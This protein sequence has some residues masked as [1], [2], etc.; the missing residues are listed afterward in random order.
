MAE[1]VSSP[2]TRVV[3]LDLSIMHKE[4]NRHLSRFYWITQTVLTMDALVPNPS[5]ELGLM[6][7]YFKLICIL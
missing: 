4:T 2:K 5:Q 7:S 6:Q 1:L 3:R